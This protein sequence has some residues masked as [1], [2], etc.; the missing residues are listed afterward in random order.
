MD[1]QKIYDDLMKKRLD[2]PPTEKFERHHIV[3]KSLGG[4]D[5]K[6][7]LVKL[8]YREHYIAH[9]LLCKIYKPKGGVD[10]ARMLFA[11]NRMRNSRDGS[12]VKNSRIFEYFRDDYAKH[13]GKV[14]SKHQS[15][16]GNS[17]Y[18]TAW[19]YHPELKISKR[20]KADD[21]IP[22]GFV[23]GRVI[24]GKPS[25]RGLI[26]TRNCK[27]CDKTFECDSS[28]FFKFCEGCRT[29]RSSTAKLKIDYAEAYTEWLKLDLTISEFA[30]LKG[31]FYSSISTQWRKLN[32]DFESEN[33]SRKLR[34]K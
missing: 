13:I 3:P 5:T 24:S 21:E 2:N 33:K 11:L 10:Y 32:L 27:N 17:Q 30:K 28:S 7:N 16:E 31:V 18:G 4:P 14:I 22:K 19:Y 25:I 15:G 1:Y 8:T 9:L 6:D 20:F 12:Q 34:K 23:K 26:E 29:A